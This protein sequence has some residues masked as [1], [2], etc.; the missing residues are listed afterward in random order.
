M[1]YW[2]QWTQCRAHCPP[3]RFRSFKGEQATV[4]LADRVQGLPPYVFA[5]LAAR[6][7]AR[8]AQGDL[9]I[10]FGMG[11]PDLPMD[12]PLVEAVCTAVRDPQSHRYPNYFGLP[13]LRAAIAAWYSGRFGVDLNPASE[14]LPLIGSKEGI[15]HAMLAFCDPGDRVLIPNPS[16]PAYRYGA[17]LASAEPCDMLLCA[18]HG[19]LPDFDV[20][21]HA[22]PPRTRVVWL[23][24]P[25]NPTGAVA[26]LAFFER[27][28]AF[29]RRHA[30]FVAHDNPYSEICFDGYRAPSILQVPG[31]REVAVEFHSLSKSYDMAGLRVGMIVGN[32]QV[33]EALGRVKSN[34]DS[35]VP[36]IVQRTAVVALTGDQSGIATRNAIY[37]AR[38]DRLVVALTAA[39]I[40]VQPPKGSLYLWGRTP[41]GLSAQVFADYLFDAAAIVVTPG[42]SFGTA[43]AGYFRLSL[44]VPDTEVT[45]AARRLAG[46]RF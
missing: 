23:N 37:A 6:I 17:L 40:A 41:A 12:L 27:A 20:L 31:A 3:G 30:I 36:T 19:F 29:A 11:D 39:G 1:V 38:R 24:Y 14:V 16:Y 25:N 44:T 9:V 18:E 35:G 15:A 13:E 7:V 2:A 43:G 8:R 34:L 5:S 26:D 4:K 45:E 46:L 42:T 22:L 32:A 33:V 10:N 21:D 28:V